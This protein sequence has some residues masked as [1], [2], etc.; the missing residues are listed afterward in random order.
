MARTNKPREQF[1]ELYLKLAQRRKEEGDLSGSLI[2]L[3][4][5][6][7]D[8]KATPEVYATIGEIYF[9]MEIYSLSR[10]Y[11]FKYL[12]SSPKTEVKL[13][14]YSALGACYCITMDNYMMGYYY[15]LEFSL[16]PQEEQEYDHVL[17]DYFD[18]TKEEFPEF[19]VTY[20]IENLSSDNLFVSAV[21]YADKG[22]YDEAIRRFSLVKPEYDDYDEA[23][24]RCACCMKEKGVS[25]A[26]I[27]DYLKD[28]YSVAQKG[29]KIPLYVCE[30]LD[31]K[32]KEELK[33]YL[34]EAEKCDS[35]E[36]ADW[37]FIARVYAEIGMDE[38]AFPALDKSLY[39]NPYEVRSLYLYAVLL[40]NAGDLKASAEYFK[41]GYDISRDVV[42]LFL[43]RLCLS[44]DAK[45]ISPTLKPSYGLPER[46]AAEIITEIALIVA[47][48]KYRLKGYTVDQL[49]EYAEFGLSFSNNLLSDFLLCLMKY[50]PAK[51]K[52]HLISRLYSETVRNYVKMH[53]I[54]ALVLTGYH[55]KVDVVF[56]G[57]LLTLKL[58]KVS[59]DGDDSSV[60]LKAYAKAVSKSFPFCRDVTSVTAAANDIFERCKALGTL[61][62]VKDENALA[63]V[64]TNEG[65][66]D[67][68][69]DVKALIK[70]FG[71]TREAF[72]KADELVFGG[73]DR[74]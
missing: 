36:P 47:G 15:D 67:H 17:M 31:K 42:N 70:L 11:W 41:K 23:A 49:I 52:N 56:D 21:D 45:T 38:K 74:Q 18:Y 24:Y 40:Y 33:K 62:E 5:L 66:S 12:S 19:Y 26:E 35:D 22:D 48:G 65:D 72:N 71:T 59:F 8:G 37:Y 54:E 1:D 27:A 30:L 55:K 20:P 7:D 10:E 28:K 16:K 6:E 4:N 3:R 73:E 44:A 57:I 60:F 58:K 39:Y 50:A 25:D 29:S 53:I 64:M 14:A 68:Q 34:A 46:A 2:V 69:F 51:V 43:Y 9:D 63:A 61:S 13:R 32:D